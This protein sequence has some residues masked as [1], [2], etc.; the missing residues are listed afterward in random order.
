MK[1]YLLLLVMFLSTPAVADTIYMS[2]HINGG[3]L[4]EEM[5]VKYVEGIFSDTVFE[6]DGRW[7]E[8]D[9]ACSDLVCDDGDK[10]ISFIERHVS[11]SKARLMKDGY[12]E[13]V[14]DKYKK[15][16]LEGKPH[17]RFA[18]LACRHVNEFGYSSDSKRKIRQE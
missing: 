1:K 2:C 17:S 13:L 6:L 10:R 14:P 8:L 5:R 15:K 18:Y 9:F 11:A 7:K 12:S 3:S 16:W 4:R